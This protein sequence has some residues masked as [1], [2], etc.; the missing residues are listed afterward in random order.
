MSNQLSLLDIELSLDTL[1]SAKVKKEDRA[2]L[3]GWTNF[4]AAFSETF[5]LAAISNLAPQK[6]SLLLDPF[7]GSGTSLVAAIKMGI[8]AIG[9]DI[10]PFACLLSRAKIA[11]NAD[12]KKVSSL[13]KPSKNK[14]ANSFSDEASSL[15]GQDCLAYASTVFNRIYKSTGTNRSNVLKTLL[16]DAEGIYDS[17]ALALGALCIGASKAAEVIK[18]S[19]PTWYRKKVDGET[20]AVEALEDA[21]K[22]TIKIMIKDIKDLSKHVSRRNIVIFNANFSELDELVRDQS[23]D[24]LIT[25]PPYMTRLDYVI[26]HLPNL[27]ILSGFIDID[28]DTL[29]RNMVGT[30]KIVSK[31]AADVKWGKSCNKTLAGIG[32]HDSYASESYYVWTYFQYFKSIYNFFSILDGKLKANGRGII[33]VQNSYYKDLEI[34][35]SKIFIEMIESFSMNATTI[36]KVEVSTNMRSLNPN[37]IQKN[38]IKKSSEDTIFLRKP[39]R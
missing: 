17:E 25:S 35:L 2:G 24:I 13:L 4:Y 15:F 16:S 21:T 7:V 11:I 31:G 23:I 30:S 8:P 28:I 37:H 33:V 38:P 10:D 39:I 6:N 14:R 27:L 26:K 29:R 32:N 9:I 12:S 1:P 18:G 5:C 22:N 36:K 34:L 20:I 3:H 19:N